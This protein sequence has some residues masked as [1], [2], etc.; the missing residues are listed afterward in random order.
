MSRRE[1]YFCFYMCSKA[2]DTQKQ[3]EAMTAA[4]NSGS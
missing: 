2:K 4:I 1:A 3:P